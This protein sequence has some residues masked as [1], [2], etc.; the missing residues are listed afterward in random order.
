[1]T[2]LYGFAIGLTS[3][4]EE[5][6]VYSNPPGLHNLETLPVPVTPPKSTFS[7]YSDV[8]E[9]GDGNIKGIGARKATWHWDYLPLEM[10]NKLREY[11][12]DT[13]NRVYIT[14]YIKDNNMELTTFSAIM[15]WPVSSEE[16]Y[17]RRL[18]D[19]TIEFK[20]LIPVLEVLSALQ[21]HT[22]QNITLTYHAP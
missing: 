19:F 6:E 17:S 11:C 12:T 7:P 22:A 14:T 16:S 1:M 21:L 4:V 9:L 18:L 13:S 20:E 8:V 2:H 15:I 10:R 3:E 5:D